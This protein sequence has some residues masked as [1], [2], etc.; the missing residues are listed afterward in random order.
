MKYLVLECSNSY[1][2]LLDEDGRFVKSANLGYE[3]GDT[4]RQPILMQDEPIEHVKEK[5]KP[6]K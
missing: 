1:A 4:V 2:V 6:F 5:E 3:V